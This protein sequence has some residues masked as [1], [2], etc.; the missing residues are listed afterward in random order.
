MKGFKPFGKKMHDGFS[1]PTKAGFTSSSG[2][3]REIAPYT[4]RVGKRKYAEGGA[5]PGRVRTPKVPSPGVGGALK[6]FVS[7]VSEAVTPRS[8]KERRVKIDQASG[9]ADGGSVGNA[10]VKRGDPSI[11]EADK[12]YGGKSPLRTGYAKGGKMK[13]KVKKGALHEALGVPQG[14]KIP[15]SKIAAAKNSS[16]PLMRKRAT[17]AQHAAK[18]GKNKG[19]YCPGKSFKSDPMF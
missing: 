11:A 9:Y 8:I 18:W 5:V 19:G 2:K 17:F 7:S 4:Q 6:D 10:V 14:E 1:F 15:K 3:V 13:I 16:S 12:E